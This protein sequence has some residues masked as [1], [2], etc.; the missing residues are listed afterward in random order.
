MAGPHIEAAS[1]ADTVVDTAVGIAADT[2][3]GIARHSVADTVRRKAADTVRRKAADTA[4]WKLADIPA[5][6]VVRAEV[7][8]LPAEPEVPVVSVSVR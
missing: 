8:L 5:E 1:A 4:G 6:L 7:V 3:A 2:V